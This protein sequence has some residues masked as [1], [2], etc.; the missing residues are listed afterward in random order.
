MLP[1]D[2]A[3]DAPNADAKSESET[4]RA[5]NLLK[6]H[7]QPTTSKDTTHNMCRNAFSRYLGALTAPP[8]S[9]RLSFTRRARSTRQGWRPRRQRRRRTAPSASAPSTARPGRLR[10]QPPPPPPPPPTANPAPSSHCRA[11]TRTT[12][13]AC[14]TSFGTPSPNAVAASSSPAVAARSA[15]GMPT[16]RPCGI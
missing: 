7:R 12:T 16:T 4:D 11:A 6:T 13:P 15:A 9:F 5:K 10:P 2:L 8:A 3:S 14:R 1:R